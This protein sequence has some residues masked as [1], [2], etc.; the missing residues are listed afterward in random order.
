[1]GELKRVVVGHDL[2]AGGDAALESAMVLADHC[3]AA[4]KLVHVVEPHHLYQMISH[5][6]TSGMSPE[7]TV[8]RAGAKLEAMVTSSEH[9]PFRAEYEVR[10]GKPFVEIILAGRAWQ[11]DLIVVGGPSRQHNP[12][13][14]SNAERLMRKATMPVLFATSPLNAN[15][16]QFLVPTDFSLGARNAAERALTLAKSFDAHILFLHVGP[17]IPRYTYY[18]EGAMGPSLPILRPMS[19][20]FKADWESLLS[21]LPLEKI[22]WEKRTEEGQA[23]DTIVEYAEAIH[24]DL[25]AMGTHGRSGL[26]HMFLGSVAKAVAQAAPCPVLTVRPEAVEFRFADV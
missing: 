24:A 2:R 4:L 3:H 13:L 8:E 25:I 7:E 5:P 20:D 14:V 10:M 18:Y 1:V 23:A 9:A 22:T 15:A 17:A 19:E 11:A 21:S 12:F 6:M 16:K 26:E